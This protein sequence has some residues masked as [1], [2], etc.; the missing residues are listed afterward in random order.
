MQISD[1]KAALLKLASAN[2]R[3]SKIKATLPTNA[4]S[5]INEPGIEDQLESFPT[6]VITKEYREYRMAQLEARAHIDAL[7]PR[8]PRQAK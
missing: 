6:Y 4:T 3:F 5:A 8:R 7:S 2:K 1:V